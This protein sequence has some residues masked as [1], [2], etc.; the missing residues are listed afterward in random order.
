MIAAFDVHYP[1][2][3]PASAAAVLFTDYDD[4]KPEAIYSTLLPAAAD[5][6]P[7][8]FYKRELPCILSLIQQMSRLPA[9]M[10]VDGY[11]MLGDK[12]GLG[13]HLFET[14]QGTIPVIGVAKSRF[15][16]SSGM[17]VFRGRSR[18]P[19]CITSAG[20]Q[21]QAACSRIRIMHGAYRIPTLLKRV[22]ALA[23]QNAQGRSIDAA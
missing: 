2:E 3:G 22:D 23:R 20:L 5:Y 15:K 8:R 9:E 14:F 18:R 12:P 16:G 19:L 13:Q 1:R 6:V 4:P 7:G 10:I 21:P 17:E 11:V